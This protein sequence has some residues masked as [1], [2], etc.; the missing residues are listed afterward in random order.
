MSRKGWILLLT[1]GV[2]WGTPYLLIRVAVTDYHPVFVA[3]GRAVLGAAILAPLALRRGVLGSGFRNLGWVALYTV[4]ELSGP[5]VLIGYAEQYVASSTAG[6]IIA[7]TPI[8]AAAFAMIGLKHSL[9]FKRILGLV[10]GLAGVAALMGFEAD[11]PHWPAFVALGLSALGYALGP[12]IVAR[13][14]SRQDA[15]GVVAASLILAALIYVPAVP[16]HWPGSFTLAATASII[17]LA[18]LCTAF[19][20]TL[21]FELINEVGAARATLVAYINPAIAVLLGVV[22][23]NEPFSLA[24]LVG[25]AL[26]AV[27]TFLATHEPRPLSAGGFHTARF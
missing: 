20:F 25:F 10:A 7:L 18:A 12:L 15:T 21:L 14:L 11:G 23:M 5:W 2:V 6:L 24:T 13:N 3:F 27:G 9:S 26:I 19:A 1:L 17:V 8:L 22:V 4:A 16:A